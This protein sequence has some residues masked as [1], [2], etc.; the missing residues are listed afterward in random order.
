M[1]FSPGGREEMECF[2]N[3]LTKYRIY[4]IWVMNLIYFKNLSMFHEFKTSAEKG[5]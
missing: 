3:D 4:Y 1:R 5:A 2:R